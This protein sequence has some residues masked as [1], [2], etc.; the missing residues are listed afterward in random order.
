MRFVHG[1]ALGV[2]LC[3]CNVP[4]QT[5]VKHWEHS[6]LSVSC[7]VLVSQLESALASLHIVGYSRFGKSVDCTLTETGHILVDEPDDGAVWSGWQSFRVLENWFL[8]T[9][10]SLVVEV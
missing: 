3:D 2:C 4:V 6:L 5:V 1:L 7:P 8:D 10:V 9:V